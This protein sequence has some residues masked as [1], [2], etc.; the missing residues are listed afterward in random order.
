MESAQAH[1]LMPR[2]ERDTCIFV[3]ANKNIM[4][5]ARVG[6]ELVHK[7]DY[8]TFN[9]LFDYERELV[10][11]QARSRRTGRL[12]MR[13]LASQGPNP[14]AKYCL[15]NLP[16]SE[17][18]RAEHHEPAKQVEGYADVTETAKMMIETLHEWT[19]LT[20]IDEL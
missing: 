4:L 2:T 1:Y 18:A 20:P 3:K 8:L 16:E 10:I 6:R 17:K 13:R 19:W 14:Y 5:P 9:A 11:L 7:A 15:D 12:L